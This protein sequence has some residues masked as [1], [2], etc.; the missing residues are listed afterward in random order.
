MK[1]EELKRYFQSNT[2]IGVYSNIFFYRNKNVIHSNRCLKLKLQK[3]PHARKTS[4]LKYFPTVSQVLNKL[5]F[6]KLYNV[7][8][9]IWADDES[10][11]EF[12]GMERELESYVQKV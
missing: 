6:V 3:F 10:F 7:L 8:I 12:Y 9:T 5:Y 2:L 4:I 1:S 11:S